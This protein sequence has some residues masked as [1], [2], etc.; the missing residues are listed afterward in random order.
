[1]AAAVAASRNRATGEELILGGVRALRFAPPGEPRARVLH[2]HGGGFRIGAPEFAADFAAA[3]AARCGV[4][5]ICPAYRLAP[6]HPFPAGLADARAVMTA[7][8]E[9]E[10]SPLILS[11]DSAGGGLAASLALLASADRRRPAGVVLLSPWLD[12]T[13]TAPSYDGNAASDPLFSRASAEP[14]A[15]LYLQGHPARDPLASPLFGQLAGFPPALVSAGDG[16][17]LVDDARSFHAALRA[18][19]ASSRL[20]VT[21]NME[22]VAVTRGLHVPG[23]AE[24]LAAVATFIDGLLA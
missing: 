11:G 9:A 8:Q 1:M 10:D 15:E 16:E 4:T 17:V 18:A 20:L 22:H 24:T 2:L 13:V 19:G 7:L 23:A 14:A 5:A 21:P 3:L 6:E 12:L